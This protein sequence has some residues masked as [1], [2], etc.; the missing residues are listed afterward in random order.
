MTD[1]G[2]TVTDGALMEGDE[3]TELDMTSSSTITEPGSVANVIDIDTVVVMRGTED[4]TDEYLF[5]AEDGTLTVTAAATPTPT[6]T[7]VPEE[8]T[9]EA[10]GG[11]ALINLLAAIASVILAG[12]LLV[13]RR[14]QDDE[15]EEDGMNR[16]TTIYKIIGAVAAVASVIIFIVTEDMRNPMI[17]VDNW[18][19][20][21]LLLTLVTIVTLYLGRKSHKSE[22]QEPTTTYEG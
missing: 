11:W 12:I 8:T 1:G 22:G 18:T 2:Y 10:A 7:E 9:P 19:V 15:S 6:E 5:T 17:M 4:V 3:I 16:N 21:M 20:I 13:S 14:S